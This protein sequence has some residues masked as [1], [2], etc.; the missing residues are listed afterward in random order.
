M[1][2]IKTQLFA[3]LPNK[4]LLRI[5]ITIG[6]SCNNGYE[7]ITVKRD[8]YRPFRSHTREEVIEY[9]GKQ[10]VFDGVGCDDET[11]LKYFPQLKPVL[12][13]DGMDM[14]GFDSYPIM[15]TRYHCANS[16]EY[17]MTQY[18]LTM[19]EVKLIPDLNET[20]IAKLMYK[21]SKERYTLE[22]AEAVKIIEELSGET[23]TRREHISHQLENDI[24]FCITSNVPKKERVWNLLKGQPLPKKYSID[25]EK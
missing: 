11:I 25:F 3:Q 7:V 2:F 17:A 15:N 24:V 6:D 1:S 23:F 14:F 22:I 12:L 19:D 5:G 18:R 16:P 8:V 9:N 4:Q 13:V 10:F 20:A 21:V